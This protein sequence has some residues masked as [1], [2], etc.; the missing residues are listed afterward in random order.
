MLIVRA[1]QMKVFEQ[2]ARLNFEDEM[3]IHSKKFSPR[4][5][6]ILGDEQL[7]SALRSAMTKAAGYG[8]TY[9]G[10]I[11]LFIEMMFLCGSGFDTDP[12]YGAIG[13]VLRSSGD[14]MLRAEQIHRGVVD[15]HERVAGPGGENVG[16]ALRELSILARMS[17]TISLD[18]FVDL[19]LQEMKRVFPEKSEDIGD[20]GLIALIHEAQKE[21]RKYSFPEPQGDALL[22]VLMFAFGHG[23]TEDPLYP[24]ISRTLTDDRIVNPVARTNR[25]KRKAVTWL[26][27]VLSSYPRAG[28]L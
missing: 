25:L 28:G 16:K 4:L 21:A 12:Q 3:V 11:R 27:H 8:F 9:R 24:W 5:C 7:R 26:D 2:A 14:Q 18:S 10:P 13:N 20:Q 15:Y 17:L 23:C 19:V 22:A 6:E 1:R